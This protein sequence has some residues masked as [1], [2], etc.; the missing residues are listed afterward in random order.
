MRFQIEEDLALSQAAA[1]AAVADFDALERRI[2]RRGIALEGKGQGAD[3]S[4]DLTLEWGGK[5]YSIATEI[6]GWAP[7]DRAGVHAT[8]SGLVAD[9]DA[10]F[11]PLGPGTTRLRIE[12]HIRS[13]G[14]RGRLAL[15]ALA[16][17]H[18]RVLRKLRDLVAGIARDAERRANVS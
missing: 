10:R 14:F 15:H 13:S 16:L 17:S 7:P 4:W 1:F 3:R 2:K 12:V 11:L 8:A 5:T 6:E 18:A 9:L